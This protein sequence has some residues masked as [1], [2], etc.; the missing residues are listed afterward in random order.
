MN[1]KRYQFL[2][3]TAIFFIIVFIGI[4]FKYDRFYRIQGMNN[5]NRV[6][7][8]T[9][10]DE[11][12]QEYLIQNNISID[13]FIDYIF[14]PEFLIYNLDYYELVE[15]QHYFTS[16]N[17]IIVH[18]NRV[19]DKL[20]NDSP[21][22]VREYLLKLMQFDVLIEY[23]YSEV[24]N[25]QFIEIYSE[26][27][28]YFELDNN[29]LVSSTNDLISNLHLLGFTNYD[30]QKTT[31]TQLFE[32][33]N[34]T[35]VN[36]LLLYSVDKGEVSFVENPTD[37][38]I[39]VDENHYI[40]SYVPNDLE[41]IEKLPRLEYFTYLKKEVYE[42]LIN[43]FNSFQ[44]EGTNESLMVVNGYESFDS[45]ELEQAGKSETQLGSIISLKIEGIS[46]EEFS[47]TQFKK[48]ADAHAHEYGFILRY[49]NLQ[50]DNIYR[51]V[52]KEV[53][54]KMHE[55]NIMSLEE[56]KEREK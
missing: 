43:L 46:I 6:L 16:L 39:I 37:L 38:T 17:D 56:Y 52:G 7:I 51:Y 5:D 36:D 50:Q 47:S 21:W 22:S 35:Q 11:L 24:F 40:S 1:F 45:L 55:E 9:Y 13:R 54:L 49:P 25:L 4:N 2:I 28:P 26:L 41:L 34:F 33:Y 18:T 27:K 20:Q 32:Y 12:E 42:A 30:S 31:L 29:D 44:N 14:F 53:A 10:L 23:E 15:N 3:I 19:V 8:E 48:W